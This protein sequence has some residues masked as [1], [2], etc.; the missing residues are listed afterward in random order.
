MS[1]VY[2]IACS[3]AALLLLASTARAYTTIKTSNGSLL[4][5]PS[6]N[7]SYY[8][9]PVGSGLSDDQTRLAI[10]NAFSSWSQTGTGLRFT[11]LGFTSDKANRFDN[12]N[13]VFWDPDNTWVGGSALA[14]TQ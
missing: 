4:R 9:N 8:I 7:I 12:K 2:R 3:T 14:R 5:W 6:R 13:V 10:Q 11:F 1:Y